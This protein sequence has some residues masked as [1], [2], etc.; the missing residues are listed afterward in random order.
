MKPV[1]KSTLP[2]FLFAGLASAQT[3]PPLWDRAAEWVQPSAAAAGTTLG[4]PAPDSVGNLVWNYE[5]QHTLTGSGIPMWS[6]WNVPTPMVVDPNLFGGSPAWVV[7]QDYG[8]AVFGGSLLDVYNNSFSGISPWKPKPFVRWE[9]TT[10]QSLILDIVGTLTVDWDGQ[11]GR[12]QPTPVDVGIVFL[13]ASKGNAKTTL[14]VAN[15]NKPTPASLQKESLILPP[16]NIQG[17]SIDPGD[18]LLISLSAVHATGSINY[19]VLRDDLRFVVGGSVPAVETVRLGVPPNPQALLPGVSSGP[20]IGKTWDPVIDHATFMPGSVLDVLILT[21]AGTNVSLPPI[22][23][24]LCDLSLP[25][26][27]ITQA[28]GVVLALPLPLDSAL[29]GVA[30]CSQGLSGDASNLR[31]TNALDITIGSH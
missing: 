11:A 1:I 2:L 21:P 24:L 16:V 14:Y 29:L 7:Q 20:V 30:L 28:P 19:A 18:S 25:T 15:V 10:G 3:V 8:A 4:N 17:V 23:T 26:L 5:W 12:I 31:L 9:N 6:Q 22:G 27:A 13:D